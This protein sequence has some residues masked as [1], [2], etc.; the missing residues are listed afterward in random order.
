M[1]RNENFG[2]SYIW[3]CTNRNATIFKRC[4][5]ALQNESFYT[6]KRVLLESKT[7]P[8]GRQKDPF[9]NFEI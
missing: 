7:S 2:S 6:V 9:L 8:F 1:T 4:S 5:F 3:L